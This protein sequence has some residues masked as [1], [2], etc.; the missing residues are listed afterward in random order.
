MA[1]VVT[2]AD[3]AFSGEDCAC[4]AALVPSEG[5]AGGVTGAAAAVGCAG[6]AVLVVGVPG[7]AIDAAV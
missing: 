4:A 6:V 3:A 7:D 5:M 1:S 2:G